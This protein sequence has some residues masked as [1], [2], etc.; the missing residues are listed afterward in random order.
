MA[1]SSRLP[2][3]CAKRTGST[4]HRSDGVVGPRSS[5]TVPVSERARSDTTR[6][7]TNAATS[8]SGRASENFPV[9][10][11]E[12][13]NRSSTIRRWLSTARRMDSPMP[14]IRSGGTESGSRPSNSACIWISI[15][16]CRSS[17]EMTAS[18]RSRA[19]V[20]SLSAARV[21]GESSAAGHAPVV[22][23]SFMRR[24]V[25]SHAHAQKASAKAHDVA[26][27]APIPREPWHL[28]RTQ[29][30]ASDTL[31]YTRRPSANPRA[32]R[33]VHHPPP[34]PSKCSQCPPT[35]HRNQPKSV[36]DSAISWCGRR[37]AESSAAARMSE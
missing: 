15:K 12:R 33:R 3:I 30:S 1:L 36:G 31:R 23:W 32:R 5:R 19:A 29:V 11:R 26:G 18:A 6:S 7:T 14:R 2:T 35:P 34:G 22:C 4:R 27:R 20:R 25:G 24:M 13:S 37:N 10:T 16:G 21:R 9:R 28:A 8:T 17:C